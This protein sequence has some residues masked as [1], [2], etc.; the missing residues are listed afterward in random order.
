[1]PEVTPSRYLVTCGWSDVPHLSEAVQTE[2]LGSIQ[3]HLRKARSQGIPSLGAGAIYP[4]AEEEVICHPFAI[5]DH[6]RRCYGMD[7]GWNNTAALWLAEDPSD[8]TIYAYAEHKRGEAVPLIHATS[9]KARGDWIPGA[10]D[11]AS[12][13]SG[14]VDG[15]KL[16][17]LYVEQGLH[18][19]V[20]DNAVEEGI[21]R[22]WERLETGRLRLFSTLVQTREEFR[23]YRRDDK[24]KV[25]KVKDHLMD[26]LRYGVS[27]FDAIAAR[28]PFLSVVGQ[29]RR[30][31]SALVGY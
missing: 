14:Q 8:G 20:A 10:I 6:W 15:R 7:V 31:G 29:G 16:F 22:V 12:M 21:Y 9:I 23:V 1:M 2:L 27:R 24:G 25:V 18:L 5:P 30:P 19:T 4:I 13:G 28:K 17:A 3:P 11:P 26:A